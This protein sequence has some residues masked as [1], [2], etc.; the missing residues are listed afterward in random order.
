MN[1]NEMEKVIKYASRI[2]NDYRYVVVD[3][4]MYYLQRPMHRSL[5]RLKRMDNQQL[6]QMREGNKIGYCFHMLDEQN[7]HMV[8]YYGEDD[9]VNE[10]RLV[11]S[12]LSVEQAH[13]IVK[14]T[15]AVMESGICGRERKV[16]L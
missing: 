12:G 13:A 7:R 11:R 15:Q 1:K 16:N 3:G 9:I 8:G 4:K 5:K 6:V 2:A 10:S 14:R